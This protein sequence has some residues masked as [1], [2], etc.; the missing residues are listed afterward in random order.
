[1]N[2]FLEAIPHSL[3]RTNFLKLNKYL[4]LGG[5]GWRNEWWLGQV[6][7]SES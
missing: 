7:N 4:I 3:T 6:I 1:M 2:F 5:A